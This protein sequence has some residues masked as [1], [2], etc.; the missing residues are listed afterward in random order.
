[1][2]THDKVMGYLKTLTID[3]AIQSYIYQLENQ[4]PIVSTSHAYYHAYAKTF[5]SDVWENALDEYFKSL[6]KRV[7]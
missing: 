1:M 6:K 3:D 5:G 4:S 7:K 2:I